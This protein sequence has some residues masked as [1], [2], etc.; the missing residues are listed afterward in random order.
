MED[1]VYFGFSVYMVRERDR[2]I[3]LLG[4]EETLI[5]YVHKYLKC[6]WTI[7]VW[8]ICSVSSFRFWTWIYSSY[9]LFWFIHSENHLLNGK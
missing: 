9:Y 4:L 6:E 2:D 5:T 1:T 8:Y 7:C 3:L